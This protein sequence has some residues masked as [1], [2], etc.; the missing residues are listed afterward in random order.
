MTFRQWTAPWVPLLV[1]V[2]RAAEGLDRETDARTKSV[3]ARAAREVAQAMRLDS[4]PVV[5]A[6]VAEAVLFLGTLELLADCVDAD[7]PVSAAIESLRSQL[8]GAVVR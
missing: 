5:D 2:L 3:V 6:F 4:P 1:V 8:R 7:A